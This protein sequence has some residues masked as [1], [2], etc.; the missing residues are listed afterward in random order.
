MYMESC[1]EGKSAGTGY[2]PAPADNERGSNRGGLP[3]VT[4]HRVRHD[5]VNLMRPADESLI[6]SLE[7]NRVGLFFKP[8]RRATGSVVEHHFTGALMTRQMAFS[9]GE[10]DAVSVSRVMHPKGRD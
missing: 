5:R 8:G 3:G 9:P 10:K 6:E 1:S 4:Y 2:A 7:K